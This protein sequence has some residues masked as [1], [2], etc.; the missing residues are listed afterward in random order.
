M[1]RNITQGLL[2]FAITAFASCSGSSSDC[3]NC[4]ITKEIS[5]ES[6]RVKTI[7]VDVRTIDEWNNDGH[8][9]CTVNYPLDELAGK[10]DTLKNFEK[11][12]LVCRSGHRAAMAKEMLEQAGLKNVENKGSWENISCK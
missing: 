3:D 11:I 5:E 7:I 8:A 6:S 1:R 4:N 2:L 10:T 12:V 9:A